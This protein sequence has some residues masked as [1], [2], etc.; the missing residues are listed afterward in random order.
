MNELNGKAGLTKYRMRCPCD[1]CKAA[2]IQK[3]ASPKNG[4]ATYCPL[5]PGRGY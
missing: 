3:A 2:N 5:R 4:N 1:Y